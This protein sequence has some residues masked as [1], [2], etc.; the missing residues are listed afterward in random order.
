MFD[1]FS[2]MIINVVA[3][4]GSMNGLDEVAI[5]FIMLIWQN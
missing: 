3:I 4:K 1:P 5:I 2:E